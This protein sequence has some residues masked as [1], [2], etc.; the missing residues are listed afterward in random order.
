MGGTA[1]AKIN[2]QD[3]G[4]NFNK[5]MDNGGLLVGNEVDVTID[6]EVV[7]KK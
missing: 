3:F 1:R 2:R 5:V 7:R 4:V 6:V